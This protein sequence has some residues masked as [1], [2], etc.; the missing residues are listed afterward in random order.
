M[1]A[2]LDRSRRYGRVVV[3]GALAAASLALPACGGTGS[4]DAPAAPSSPGGNVDP[5]ASSGVGGAINRAKDTAGAVEQ[6][7]A[8]LSTAATQP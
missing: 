6:H 7:D 3:A 4:G 8:T 5:A 2:L 1:I